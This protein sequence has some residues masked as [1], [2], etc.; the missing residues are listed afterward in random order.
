MV[1]HP[2]R[3]VTDAAADA[4][5]LDIGVGIGAVHLGLLITAGGEK[6]GRGSRVGLLAALSEPRRDAYEI[7]LGDARLH[8]L[9]REFLGEGRERRRTAR[10]AAKHDDIPVLSGAFCEHFADDLPV[11]DFIHV[12]PSPPGV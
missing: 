6:A 4:N 9:P 1:A 2:Q 5:K 8:E 3:A 11:G 7:L 12:S 10:I